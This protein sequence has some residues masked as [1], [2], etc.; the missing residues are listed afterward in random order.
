MRI[1][2]AL[3]KTPKSPPGNNAFAFA[4]IILCMLI[5]A[6][7]LVVSHFQPEDVETITSSPSP[8]RNRFSSSFGGTAPAAALERQGLTRS[9]AREILAR[10]GYHDVRGFRSD[11][12]YFRAT[13]V[14]TGNSWEVEVDSYTQVIARAPLSAR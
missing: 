8:S 1:Q 3:P 10:A 5:S 2:R 12:L 6:A 9:E 11:G 14:R 7:L 13:A 4:L